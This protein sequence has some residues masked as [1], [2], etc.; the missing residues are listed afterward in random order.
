MRINTFIIVINFNLY[1]KQLP[2]YKN[3]NNKN[4]N[5][6]INLKVNN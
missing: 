3:N 1:P 4:L 5:N 2:N 6:K